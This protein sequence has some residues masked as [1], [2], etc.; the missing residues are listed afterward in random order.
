MQPTEKAQ[1]RKGRVA[2]IAVCIQA[3]ITVTGLL[4]A[5]WIAGTPVAPTPVLTEA[6]I[7]H[8]RQACEEELKGR[9][10][11]TSKTPD[12]NIRVRASGETGREMSLSLELIELSCPGYRVLRACIGPDCEGTTTGVGLVAE[13]A[14]RALQER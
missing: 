12:G 8:A 14:P 13:L 4:S 11:L 5:S 3:V 9:S 2:L 1:G 10:V 6:A 7:G